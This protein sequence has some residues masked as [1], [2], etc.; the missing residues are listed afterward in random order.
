[1]RRVAPS[2]LLLALGCVETRQWVPEVEPLRA[3]TPAP[4]ARAA[5]PPTVGLRLEEVLAGGLEA[6]DFL[7]GLRV[8]RV[9]D[10]SPAQAAGI[11]EGDTVLRAQGM[12]LRSLDQWEAMLASRSPG[13]EVSLL[14]DRDGGAVEVRVPLVAGGPGRCPSPTRFVERW[15]ARMIVETVREEGAPQAA[16][17][18]RIVELL[19]ASPLAGAGLRR[20]DT[21]LGLDGERTGGA[22]DLL[23]RLAARDFGATI[24]LD[25]RRAAASGTSRATRR[26]SVRLWAPARHTT[27]VSLP[28]LLDWR[29]DPGGTSADLSILDLWILSLFD[30]HREGLARQW[31]VLRWIAWETDAGALEELERAP[32]AGGTR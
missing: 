15:K 25:V 23:R 32:R 16:C 29:A 19:P 5:I 8:A 21:I 14:L 28:I 26:V 1:M 12:D 22:A 13:E 10:G 18:A 7:R 27:R 31:R 17:G 3:A 20:G 30:Y 4:E 9:A 11:R 6:M 2:V 24:V